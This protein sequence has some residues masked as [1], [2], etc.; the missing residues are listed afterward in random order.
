MERDLIL[1]QI[2]GNKGKNSSALN[3]F[4]IFSKEAGFAAPLDVSRG[5]VNLSFFLASSS[6]RFFAATN[7]SLA[8]IQRCICDI[9]YI[10]TIILCRNYHVL[11]QENITSGSVKVDPLV[12]RKAL[13]RTSK[14]GLV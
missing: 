13:N 6:Q 4:L 12:L 1:V 10:S 8:S 11:Q 7:Y 9:K 14:T 5:L 3:F 2:E